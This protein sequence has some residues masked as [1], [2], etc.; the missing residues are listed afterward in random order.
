MDKNRGFFT[1]DKSPVAYFC[2]EKYVTHFYFDFNRKVVLNIT[3]TRLIFYDT[4]L[5]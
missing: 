2:K 1:L 5:T 3:I 4:Y